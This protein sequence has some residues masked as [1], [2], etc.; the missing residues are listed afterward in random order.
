MNNEQEII[1]NAAKQYAEYLISCI[2]QKDEEGSV[3]YYFSGSLAMLLLNSVKSVNSIYIDKDGE[4]IKTRGERIFSEENK[5]HLEQGIRK[6]S[7]DIDVI[8]VLEKSFT[9]HRNIY[10]TK[11]VRENCD[12]VLSLCPT[13]KIDCDDLLIDALTETREFVGHDIAELT[14]NDGSIV[15]TADPL[16]MV[17]H[18]F[19]DAMS[20]K[21]MIDELE[22]KGRTIAGKQTKYKK[23]VRDFSSMFNGCIDLYPNVDFSQVVDHI[24]KVYPD[25]CFSTLMQEQS[26]GLIKRFYEDAKEQIAD[27]HQELFKELIDTASKKNDE[28][29][30]NQ[31]NE[32]NV[33]TGAKSGKNDEDIKY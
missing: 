5:K 32:S 15:I 16:C 9:V 33:H 23:C 10:S 30:H 22:K 3:K 18:K 20:C 21:N 12:L 19:A 24:L 13:W 27:E 2:P 6:I 26:S 17:F 28:I 7:L 8:E 29:L 11:A 14:L 1:V 25:T 31:T 4:I